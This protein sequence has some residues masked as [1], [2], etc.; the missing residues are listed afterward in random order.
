MRLALVRA[1]D[2]LPRPLDPIRSLKVKLGI[3]LLGSGAAGGGYFIYATGG[4]PSVRPPSR[5]WSRC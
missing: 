3:L 2:L 5:S 1:W 4:I